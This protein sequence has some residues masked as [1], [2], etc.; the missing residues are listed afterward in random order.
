M[1]RVSAFYWA[2]MLS[3]IPIDCTLPI[4]LI[5]LVY[6]MGGLRATA[7]AFFSNLAAIV[8]LLLVAQSLGLVIG[9]LVPFPKT[10]QTITTVV[11]LSMVLVAGF[12]VT[13]IP[14]WIAWLR[15]APPARPPRWACRV[16]RC[17]LGRATSQWLRKHVLVACWRP[18]WVDRL[19]CSSV[20]VCKCREA[21][22]LA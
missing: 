7:A 8:L 3:D 12:F 16:S 10:A 1:Y 5:I 4:V 6:W 15:C 14:V 17:T 13:N 22:G 20:P 19:C 2:R 11:A 21:E 9:A 18:A